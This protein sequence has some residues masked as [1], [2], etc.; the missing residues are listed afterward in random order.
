IARHLSCP[1][2]N[3]I[4][5]GPSP[6]VFKDSDDLAGS[7]AAHSWFRYADLNG[8]KLIVAQKLHDVR[9]VAVLR[10]DCAALY[11]KR[12]QVLEA[13]SRRGRKVNIDVSNS[14]F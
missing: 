6:S 1:N 13:G 7:E 3:S 14:N 4:R 12:E 8:P 9:Q 2:R 11:D 5:D 10:E